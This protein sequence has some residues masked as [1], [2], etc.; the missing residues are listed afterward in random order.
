MKE[1]NVTLII[2]DLFI[3]KELFYLHLINQIKFILI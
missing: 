1:S 2:E 3:I